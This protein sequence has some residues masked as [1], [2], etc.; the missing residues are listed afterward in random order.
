M[1]LL[2]PTLRSISLHD[3]SNPCEHIF[4]EDSLYAINAALAANRPLL[5]RGEPGTGKSQLARAAAKAL[6][7]PFVGKVLDAHTE[8]TDLL[9]TLDAVERLA[10]AQVLGALGHVSPQEV[11]ASLAE[12][13]FV[14]PGPLWWAFDWQS[15]ATQAN[16]LDLE[17]PDTPPPEWRDGDGVVVLVDEIDKCEASVPNGLLEALGSGRFPGPARMPAIVQ[18]GSAPLVVITTNEERA[19]PDAF[20][21][22]CLVL[23][24]ELPLERAVLVDFLVRRGRAHAPQAEDSVLEAAAQL[25]V[26]D[27]ETWRERGLAPPGQAEYLDLVMAVVGQAGA[28]G[29]ADQLQL[30]ERIKAFALS[31]HPRDEAEA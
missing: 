17:A 23:Q 13:R 25:L 15:A 10:Q 12:S 22:R 29:A 11:R 14:S 9:W 5:V 31:K 26:A 6:G 20:L 24:L 30:L 1:K 7:R 18:R 3:R 2:D 4:E 28:K 19:L 16:A 21:R 27:R 8:S